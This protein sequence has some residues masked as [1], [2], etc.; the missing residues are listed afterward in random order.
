MTIRIFRFFLLPSNKNNNNNDNIDDR[1][2]KYQEIIF[3]LNNRNMILM[4]RTEFPTHNY[5]MLN[6]I[7]EKIDRE[8]VLNK[9][10][11]DK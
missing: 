4:I 3:F 1:K 5:H 6:F 11:T 10:Q 2:M 7:G 9:G 8:N